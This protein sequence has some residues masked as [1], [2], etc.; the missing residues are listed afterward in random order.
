MQPHPVDN[1][2]RRLLT[3]AEARAEIG[4]GLS[5]FNKLVMSGDISVVWIGSIRRVRRSDL[6]EFLASL[7]SSKDH[8]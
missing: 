1:T 5:T 3:A 2:P 8:A 6:D 4:V 7:P